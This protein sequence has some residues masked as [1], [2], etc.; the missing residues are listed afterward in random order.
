MN[1][2]SLLDVA[3]KASLLMA[4]RKG[5]FYV[6]AAILGGAFML[7]YAISSHFIAA[8]NVEAAKD[9]L[10][11]EAVTPMLT[12]LLGS[13]TIL[14]ITTFLAA[15]SLQHFTIASCRN[16]TSLFP[17]RPI[18][19]VFKFLFMTFGLSFGGV[20]VVVIAFLPVVAL[21]TMGETNTADSANETIL[22]AYAAVVGVLITALLTRLSFRLTAI[23][24]DD[25]SSFKKTWQMTSGHTVRIFLAT[26][27]LS[28]PLGVLQ[29]FLPESPDPVT[30][31]LVQPSLPLTL[32][33]CALTVA[34]SLALNVYWGIFYQEF[35]K[36]HDPAN[37]SGT[38]EADYGQ[39]QD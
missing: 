19:A 14:V 26:I 11:L 20:T 38:S 28:A 6:Y 4:A 21:L 5:Y 13:N 33:H 17:P 35:K 16:T 23:T 34:T 22:Y 12:W 27:A 7:S 36:Q 31:L 37:A 15:F 32:L 1:K 18:K 9:Q 2:I 30:N 10:D 24:V 29:L 25:D 8:F 39:C 3:R